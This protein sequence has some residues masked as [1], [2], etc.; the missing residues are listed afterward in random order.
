MA[1]GDDHGRDRY[2][3]TQRL[4]WAVGVVGSQASTGVR[5][6]AG[7][8]R[9]TRAQPRSSVEATAQT[10]PETVS[11]YR[12]PHAVPLL[13][14]AI[15]AHPIWKGP[16]L[17]RTL[18]AL[19]EGK[20][21][22]LAPVL[23][24]GMAGSLA[25]VNKRL[26][27]L[28]RVEQAYLYS[29]TIK[30]DLRQHLEREGT[31][32]WVLGGNPRQSGQTHLTIPDHGIRMKV[33]KENSRIHPGGVPPANRT[34]NDRL[35]Y[36]DHRSVQTMLEFPLDAPNWPEGKPINLIL[37]WDYLRNQAGKIDYNAFTLRAVHTTAPADFGQIVPLDLSFAIVSP[38]TV[39]THSRFDGGDIDEDLYSYQI[40]TTGEMDVN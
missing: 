39:F 35:M 7:T 16:K 3:K 21:Q 11:P 25:G 34:K 40:D 31:G 32:E 37:L 33:V 17:P 28:D 1:S 20:I 13:S 29:L 18:Q 26:Q 15:I 19:L 27:G 38:S 36:T 22:A 5:T 23:H 4:W 8:Q 9:V 10:A 30:A 14:R 24:T 12:R 6:L 2:V